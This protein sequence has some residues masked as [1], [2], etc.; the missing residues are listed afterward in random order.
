MLESFDK[1]FVMQEASEKVKPSTAYNKSSSFFDTLDEEV[2]HAHF[3]GSCPFYGLQ[4]AHGRLLFVLFW[5]ARPIG[6]LFAATLSLC[7][8]VFVL[9]ERSGSQGRPSLQGPDAQER[10][11]YIWRG[12]AQGG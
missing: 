6:L 10:R 5:V 8:L 11:A 12:H 1:A 3:R 2:S 7:A 4:S 9:G